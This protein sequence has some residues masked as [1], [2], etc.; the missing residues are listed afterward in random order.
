MALCVDSKSYW[1]LPT[2]NY[3]Q[4]LPTTT[5][6][7]LTAAIDL[8]NSGAIKVYGYTVLNR[9]LNSDY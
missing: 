1:L 3:Y 2:I 6:Y 9:W 8:L 4:L 5:N 7:L